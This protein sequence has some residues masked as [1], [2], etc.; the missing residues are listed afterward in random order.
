VRETFIPH[1]SFG[2]PD[3]SGRLKSIICG[4]QADFGYKKCRTVI[5]TIASDNLEQALTKVELTLDVSRVICP[6]CGAVNLFPG[7]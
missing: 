1:L 3:W 2:V 7:Y 6:H 4:E 5:H